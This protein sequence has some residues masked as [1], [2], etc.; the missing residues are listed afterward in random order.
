MLLLTQVLRIRS[1]LGILGALAFAYSTYN[2]VLV[3]VG[4]ETKL[5]ALILAPA[6][7]AGFL[8]L[9]EV[10]YLWGLAVLSIFFGL[11]VGTQHVQVVYY[12]VLVLGF[13][14]ICNLIISYRTKTLRQSLMGL[15]LSVLGGAVGFGTYA[16]SMLPMQEYAKETMRGGKSELTGD[17][18]NKTKGGLDK[19]YAFAWSYGIG[20]TATLL[21]PGSYGGS[22]GGNGKEYSGS[23]NFTEKLAEA[24]M[25]EE[26]ALQMENA[27]SYWGL[28]PGT[29]GP[30]Y[31]GAI[32]CFLFIFG[33]VYVKSWHKWWIV[34]ATILGI[35]LAWGKNF[36][37]F[38]YFLFDYLPFYNKFRAPSM[39]L[40]IPQLTVPLLGVLAMEQLFSDDNK[41]ELIWK[42]FRFSVL[43]TAGVFLLVGLIY[44]S[45]DFKG[46]NDARIRENFAMQAGGN[47][48]SP[49]AQQQAQA[50]ASS[51]MNALEEDRKGL[52]RSD[53]LRS[54]TLV[55]IAVSLIGAYLKN[56]LKPMTVMIVLAVLSTFDVLAIGRRYL[57]NDKY[58]DKDEFENTIQPSAA[59]KQIMADPNKP[60]R[61]FDQTEEWYQSSRASWFHNSVGGYHPA[62]LGLYQDILEN[63]LSKGNMEVFNM[64]NT[65]YFI[66]VNPATREPVAQIN[67]GAFG[68]VWFVK[69]I[70]YVN[71]SDEEMQAL[72][73]TRL[74]DTAVIQK[75]FQ[76][77]VKAAPQWD[78]TATIR[79]LENNNDVVKYESNAS[80]PQ[81]AVFSEIY[82]PRGW[83]VYVDGNKSEYTKVNYVLRGMTVPAGKHAIEFRFEPQSYKLGNTITTIAGILAYLLLIAA[84]VMEVRRKKHTA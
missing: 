76:S 49:Q 52:F 26:S 75:K 60:F 80:A 67:P 73:S 65:K 63:Q 12:T 84:I 66:S 83:N 18:K 77:Q 4:H 59:D 9:L 45:S 34:A 7:I 41:R 3:S 48:P 19:S 53:L 2:P 25:P 28:Q 37:A 82:Y 36:S 17:E 42:K 68:P 43:I 47:N 71:N 55:L 74:R 61:V 64:L 21:V 5:Q 69:G 20:E 58:V 11:Q 33:L 13:I 32:I 46:R 35:L 23:T 8:M 24:G 38:N 51:L 62:K 54:F 15:A 50:L 30:V 39:G 70:K 31:L 57:N 79:L 14:A 40:I 78:S 6:V 81:F 22:D 16:V 27:Y 1:W 72:D 29:G 56:K 10:K 44:L